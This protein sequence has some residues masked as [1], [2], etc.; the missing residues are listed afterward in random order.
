MAAPITTTRDELEK[1]IAAASVHMANAEKE[2]RELTANEREEVDKHLAAAREARAKL[3]RASDHSKL[4]AEIDDLIAGGKAAASVAEGRVRLAGRPA[5]LGAQFVAS[6]AFDFIRNG[7]IRGASAWATPSV[8]LVAAT[9]TEDPA[10]GGALV[11]PD[12]RPGILGLGFQPLTVADLLAPGRTTSNAVMYM[13]EKTAVNAAA[14][15]AEGAPKPESTLTFENKTAPVAKVAT[16]LPVSEEMLADE[17]QIRSYIDARLSLFV[18]IAMEDQ[19]LNGDGI[20]PNMLGIRE[21]PGLAPAVA[22]DAAESNAD[23]IAR[24]IFTIMGTSFITPDGIVLNPAD[25]AGVALSKTSQGVYYAGGPFAPFH[26]PTLWGLPVAV[27]TAMPAGTGL[28]GAF[29]TG[30][31]LWQRSGIVV[32]A[33]NSHADYFIRNL[34]AIRAEQRAVVTVYRPAAFGEVT[35]LTSGLEAPAG[36]R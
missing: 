12:V 31:Q 18:G 29:K 1:A 32:A 17:A 34:V 7:G 28:V 8:E 10:S 36:A 16:W 35:D 25:W 24:Q 19:I 23:A 13:L 22:K 14:A 33:S 3:A 5:S 20:A 11:L 15:V 27:T 26:A 4:A 2:N 6:A 21:T 30:A 9:L